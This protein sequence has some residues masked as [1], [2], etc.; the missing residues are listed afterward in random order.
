MC[1]HVCSSS[2]SSS[3]GSF[4]SIAEGLK[5]VFCCKLKILPNHICVVADINYFHYIPVM[6]NDTVKT[7]VCCTCSWVAL[8]QLLRREA[9]IGSKMR[10]CFVSV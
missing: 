4:T 9:D 3:V 6:I 8:D 7:A 10:I 2:F 5:F 1:V